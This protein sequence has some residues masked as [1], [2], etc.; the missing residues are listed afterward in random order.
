M[1]DFEDILLCIEL[2]HVIA[3]LYAATRLQKLQQEK[4]ERKKRRYWVR[5]ILRKRGKEGSHGMLIPQLMSDNFH[6]KNYLRMDKADFITV[7]SYIEPLISCA[8]PQFRQSISASLGLSIKRQ[9]GPIR[10]PSYKNRAS[11]C[12]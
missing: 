10:S 3:I 9:T 1:E 11:D 4:N 12:G 5:P 7:L 6:Y 2:I 8:D